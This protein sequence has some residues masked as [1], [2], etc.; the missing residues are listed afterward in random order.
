[1]CTWAYARLCLC[2]HVC[3]QNWLAWTL[4]EAGKVQEAESIFADVLSIALRSQGPRGEAVTGALR[5]HYH[6]LC[7]QGRTAEAREIREAAAR[8]GCDV[9]A[10]T[11]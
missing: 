6:L 3:L 8:I 11:P 1:M 10:C 2:V 9:S 5:C 4:Q 7:E